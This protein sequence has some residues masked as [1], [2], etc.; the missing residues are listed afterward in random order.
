MLNRRPR[1]DLQENGPGGDAQ[2]LRS[3]VERVNDERTALLIRQF[4]GRNFTAADQQRLDALTARMVELVPGV[5][6][7]DLAGAKALERRLDDFE[8]TLL[9]IRRKHGLGSF[10]INSEAI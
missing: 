2:S 8:R 5:T 4:D 10:W 7:E 6:Q 1:H 3:E 9:Q